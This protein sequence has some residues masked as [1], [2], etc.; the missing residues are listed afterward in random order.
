MN[1]TPITSRDVDP[2]WEYVDRFEIALQKD[3]S[4][5]VFDY[6]PPQ[7]SSVYTPVLVELARIK[8]EHAWTAGK[9]DSLA[10]ILGER[11]PRLLD[12]SALQSIV[13]EDFRQRLHFELQ[14]LLE[15]YSFQF[16]VD[17]QT[18]ANLYQDLEPE[19]AAGIR[20]STTAAAAQETVD[21]R[22]KS[23]NRG[24]HLT[25]EESTERMIQH[26]EYGSCFGEFQVLDLLGE[27][28][29][30]R[31][32]LA[33]Q[34]R[35][36]DRYVVLKLTSMPLGESEKL[37][38][39]QHAN[40]VPLYSVHRIGGLFAICMP[41]LGVV[42][43]KDC[44]RLNSTHWKNTGRPPQTGATYTHSIMQSRAERAEVAESCPRHLVE[45][46]EAQSNVAVSL[47]LARQIAVGLDHAHQRG[48]LHRDVKPANILLGFDGTPLLLDFNLSHSRDE[49]TTPIKGGT[50]PY[51]SPEQCRAMGDPTVE[52]G[53][54][55]DVYS[56]GVVLYEMLTGRLPYEN[57]EL[58]DFEYRDPKVVLEQRSKVALPPSRLNTSLSQ[59]VDAILERCLSPDTASRYRS[60]AELVEDL[61]LELS[62]RPLRHAANRAIG[63]RITK[64]CRRHRLLLRQVVG[65]GALVCLLLGM[66]FGYF[67]LRTQHLRNRALAYYQEFFSAARQ[68]EAALLFPD[69]GTY[70]IGL[71]RGLEVRN[72]YATP[73]SDTI[74]LTSAQLRQYLL[75]EQAQEFEDQ[76]SHL[77][78]LIEAAL[79]ADPREAN[80][81]AGQLPLHSGWRRSDTLYAAIEKFQQRKY[82]DAIEQLQAELLAEPGRFASRFLLGNC[83][84][85]LRDY[86]QADQAFA[87]A[88]DLEP[89]SSLVLLKRALCRYQMGQLEECWQFLQSAEGLDP[90]NPQVFSNK[91]LVLERQHRYSAAIAEIETARALDP[92]SLRLRSIY[93]RLLRAVGDHSAAERELAALREQ[94]PDTPEDWV[95]RGIARIGHSAES[96]LEDF[97]IA[98]QSPTMAVVAR[99]N[100]AHV[101]SEKLNR[102]AESINV[103]TDLLEDEPDF[104]PALVGRAVLRARLKMVKE[105]EEDLAKCQQ[106][107]LTPQAHYQIACV[108]AQL[109]TD[110]PKYRTQARKHLALA[111]M[112]LYSTVSPREDSDLTALFGDTDFQ[113]VVR[114]ID[115]LKQWRND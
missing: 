106:L 29:F 14:G 114:G 63:E 24:R 78:T 6:L 50:L 31:V 4:I 3:G 46:Y 84:F 15:Y 81:L 92:D 104:L 90:E 98:A 108:Y 41:L 56:L 58:A 60:A 105:A 26:L 45:Q 85:E 44:L 73:N 110:D 109:P 65:T 32:Y 17:T 53:P 9:S 103:L 25:T 99:Q 20:S 83:F 97:A 52:V 69:G 62:D 95:M 112:P 13:F 10:E 59:S 18:W 71:K 107:I 89:R 57:T 43:L 5:S 49:A 64:Y 7:D 66:L 1:S 76:M 40:I 75:P 38:R 11:L 55:S 21:W 115:V 88:S 77:D 113:T 51:M 70:E 80:R 33:R 67:Q 37:A 93:G 36:A 34:K 79:S 111:L 27:G 74:N 23:T 101:L 86:R 19:R 96:A 100:M 8:I 28:A 72:L 48:V 22:S 30:S 16:G 54:A 82:S 91:A 68:A 102:P 35:L 42:T 2:L 61:T 12:K 87:V 47:E 94:T 39:L